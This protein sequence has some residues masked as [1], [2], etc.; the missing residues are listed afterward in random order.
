MGLSGFLKKIFGIAPINIGESD[1]QALREI[2][3]PP[4][5]QSRPGH[6]ENIE[7]TDDYLRVIKLLEEGSPI[8]FV[9]GKAGTGKSVL[10]DYICSAIKKDN[11]AVLAPTGVAALNVRGQTIHSFFR[12][13]PRLITDE[14]IKSVYDR[15]LYSKLDLLVIDEISMVRADLFEGI[16]KFL[17]INGQN[18]GRPFGGTQLLIV[19][20]P[21]QLPPVITTKAE[22]DHLAG[23]NG[24]PFFFNTQSWL[25]NRP[26]FIELKRNFRQGNSGFAEI[27]DKIRVA[28]D[29]DTALPIINARCVPVEDSGNHIVTLTGTH[30]QADQ[31]NERE[32]RKLSG[33][34]RTFM[35]EVSGK[36]S[37]EN[38]KLPVPINLTLKSGAIVMFAKNDSQ[39]RWVN[40]T[41]GRVVGF[42][43]NSIKVE[44]IADRHCRIHDVQKVAWEIFEYRYDETEGKIKPVIAGRYVQFPL[45]LAWAVTIHKAQGKTLGRILIDL[46]NRAFASGQ[47]YVALSRCRSLEDIYLTR[48]INKEDV[49]CDESIKRFYSNL[50]NG[51]Q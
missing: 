7:V 50:Q 31:I 44:V 51:Q 8:I 23:K 20:D 10:I 17:R 14:D 19:G 34:P 9:S 48:P 46:G 21:Y 40:G 25:Q 35:G 38:K 12:F 1:R 26:N 18:P 45:M 16:D 11:V 27:L 28:E 47:V 29:L 32:I 3:S 49:I 41:I 39:K 13:P 43:H 6:L 42:R 24:G 36:F 22:A 15:N 37:S 5:M 2:Y 30:L 33:R 4:I